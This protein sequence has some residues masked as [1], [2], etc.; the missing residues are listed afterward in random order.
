MTLACSN[1]LL[2]TSK[3]KDKKSALLIFGKALFYSN[4]IKAKIVRMITKEKL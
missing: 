4:N 3:S 1:P 2:N